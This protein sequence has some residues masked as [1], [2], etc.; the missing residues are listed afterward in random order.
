MKIGFNIRLDTLKIDKKRLFVGKKGTYLNLSAF[1]DTEE[2]SEYGD[3]GTVRQQTSKE[4][5][6]SGVSLPILGNCKVY[7][8]GESEKKSLSPDEVQKSF[9]SQDV[10]EDDIPF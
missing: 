9:G 8:T 7:Y 3:H 10:E 2:T 5:R 6:D 4:E 1:I